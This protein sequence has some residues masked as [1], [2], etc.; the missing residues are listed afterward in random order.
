[1]LYIFVKHNFRVINFISGWFN[2]RLF[3]EAFRHRIRNFHIHYW[4]HGFCHFN[5]HNLSKSGIESIYQWNLF[6]IQYNY[7]FKIDVIRKI[8]IIVWVFINASS[9]CINII[10]KWIFFV[11]HIAKKKIIDRY[12]F[13]HI[14]LIRLSTL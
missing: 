11:I 3:H 13:F 14:S 1:M 5:Y 9:I 4:N 2:Y 8:S 7:V 10:W 12:N 6:L